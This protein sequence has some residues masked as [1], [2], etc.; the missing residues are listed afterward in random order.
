MSSSSGASP[1]KCVGCDIS[2]PAKPRYVRQDGKAHWAVCTAQTLTF[3]DVPED[4]KAVHVAPEC[5]P[6]GLL[7]SVVVHRT[8][9]VT[10][11][12]TR[13]SVA[14]HRLFG[15]RESEQRPFDVPIA[16]CGYELNIDDE[17]AH[18]H[19]I[20]VYE[21]TGH[22][23]RHRM[24]AGCSVMN[25][26]V[27]FHGGASP[28]SFTLTLYGVNVLPEALTHGAA[29]VLISERKR[30]P[31]GM[32]PMTPKF[33]QLGAQAAMNSVQASASAGSAAPEK[34]PGKKQ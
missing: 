2:L 9:G 27:Q 6:F 32:P 21:K 1:V 20:D 33:R 28:A 18:Q 5:L 26:A 10:A 31:L 13:V 15:R 17:S 22:D 8:D 34:K 14:V 30:L 29:S 19:I 7:E 11:S 23:F 12:P 25:L 16:L 4:A 3:T 24:C